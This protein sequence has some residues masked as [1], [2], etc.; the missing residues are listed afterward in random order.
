MS[1]YPYFYGLLDF[2]I[3][4][5][6]SLAIRG[7]LALYECVWS[8]SHSTCI[9]L[10]ENAE[11]Q[12]NWGLDWPDILPE[13]MKKWKISWPCQEPYLNYSFI[14]PCHTLPTTPTAL[15]KLPF[16]SLSY[17]E[18][19]FYSC[20]RLSVQKPLL[21]YKEMNLEVTWK[22]ITVKWRQWLRWF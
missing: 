9:S 18:C 8:A 13:S 7:T 2:S 5:P 19:M 6:H 22:W 20:R 1:C 12:L 3:T 15:S 4:Y 16:Y 11:Y 21:I 14:Y 10:W 17:P